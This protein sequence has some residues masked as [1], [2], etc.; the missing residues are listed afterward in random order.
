MKLTEEDVEKVLKIVD[1][2]DFREVRLE[3]GEL[4]LHVVKVPVGES[5]LVGS[6]REVEVGPTAPAPTTESPSAK[7]PTA[8]APSLSGHVVVAPFAGMVYHSPKPGAPPYVR[9]GDLVDSGETVCLLEVMKL[10]QSVAAGIRGRLTAV[11][12]EDGAHVEEGQPLFTIDP[13]DGQ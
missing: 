10:F 13:G 9:V 1:Q 3:F 2:L 11:L 6:I 4:K 5:A 12:V 7:K 8:P